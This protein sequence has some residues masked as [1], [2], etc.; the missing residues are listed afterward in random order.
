MTDYVGT[1]EWRDRCSRY[2]RRVW[3]LEHLDATCVSPTGAIH[4]PVTAEHRI[5]SDPF[6][7][8]GWDA[9]PDTRDVRPEREP[10][11]AWCTDGIDAPPY[12]GLPGC[13]P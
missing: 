7:G 13:K 1:P 11:C 6:R 12:C 4:G 3:A 9:V 5:V 10:Y 2:G 8:F